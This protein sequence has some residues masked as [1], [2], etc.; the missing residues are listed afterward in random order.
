MV[1]WK[2]Y[3]RTKK[4]VEKTLACNDAA[5]GS[6]FDYLLD[7]LVEHPEADC[8]VGSL[9]QVPFQFVYWTRCNSKQ[10]R[11]CNN[12]IRYYQIISSIVVHWLAWRF[13]EAHLCC[14]TLDY[15]AMITSVPV[16][17]CWPSGPLSST[18][19]SS[20]AATNLVIL[21]TGTCQTGKYSCRN[22][23]VNLFR[24][25]PALPGRVPMDGKKKSCSLTEFGKRRLAGI[26]L[27]LRSHR[28]DASVAVVSPSDSLIPTSCTIAT[29]A[30][31]YTTHRPC[32]KYLQ[33][34]WAVLLKEPGLSPLGLSV[35]FVVHSWC[36]L[37]AL[38]QFA[39]P[40]IA[41]AHDHQA[42]LRR[43][44]QATLRSST[45]INS[46]SMDSGVLVGWQMRTVPHSLG[47]STRSKHFPNRPEPLSANAQRKRQRPLGGES[48]WQ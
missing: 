22:F 7:R 40:P 4:E 2:I 6:S 10:N 12:S 23:W 26:R 42:S 11:E 14:K 15:I 16:L 30:W 20:C 18:R 38:T 8:E 48:G 21:G 39:K 27:R 31:H 44:I 43:P 35:A 24:K 9:M 33:Q 36:A 32:H 29:L 41:C 25:M 17:S 5:K 3:R 45:R 13:L 37:P 34:V 46:A 28:F 1:P 47:A 19:C